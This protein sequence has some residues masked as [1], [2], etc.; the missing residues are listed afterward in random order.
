MQIIYI[1]KQYLKIKCLFFYIL[2]IN[3]YK[4]KRNYEERKKIKVIDVT[5]ISIKLHS[6]K[7][8]HT[9]KNFGGD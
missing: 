7:I 8:R 1:Q 3:R 6:I 4:E 5:I 9:I 2:L